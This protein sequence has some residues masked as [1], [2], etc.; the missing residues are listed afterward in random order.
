[1]NY[2][3]YVVFQAWNLRSYL[4][5]QDSFPS[6]G[7]GNGRI[8]KITHFLEHYTGRMNANVVISEADAIMRVVLRKA[9]KHMSCRDLVFARKLIT[10]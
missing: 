10:P 8:H 6:Q 4:K 5:A 1:M 3:Y 9:E 7:Q 2:S